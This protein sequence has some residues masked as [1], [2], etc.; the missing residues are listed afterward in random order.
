M[1]MSVTE[2]INSESGTILIQI[3]CSARSSRLLLLLLKITTT[4]LWA[5]GLCGGP[6]VAPGEVARGI[7]GDQSAPPLR[8]TF[9]TGSGGRLSQSWDAVLRGQT[10]YVTPP[11]HLLL[12]GSREAF[13]SLLEAAEDQLKCKYV[14]V[15]FSSDQPERA[16]LVRTF[17]FLGFSVL[18]PNSPLLPAQLAAGNICMLYNIEE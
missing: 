7:R 1:F 10:L 4:C 3:R 18:S 9:R 13:I 15:V 2:A 12:E 8:L 11:P 6:D 14:I 16:T 17:M 5:P